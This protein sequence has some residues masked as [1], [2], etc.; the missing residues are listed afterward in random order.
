[1]LMIVAFLRLFRP[2]VYLCGSETGP[3]A[4]DEKADVFSF[5]IL[6]YALLTGSQHPYHALFL[7]PGQAVAAVAE[8]NLRPPV[9]AD[10]R[11]KPKIV[12]FLE[13]AWAA[14]PADRPSMAN[15]SLFLLN[16][17]EEERKAAEPK[18]GDSDHGGLQSWL[19]KTGYFKF[20]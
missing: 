8:K 13:S 12:G 19:P 20:Y 5:A 2:E 10:L 6:L 4:Y 7:T 16:L 1:M 9:T 17:L 14:N 3:R 15:V 11:R 18:S